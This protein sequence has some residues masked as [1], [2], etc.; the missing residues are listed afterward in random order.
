M[1]KITL[2]LARQFIISNQFDFEKK[3]THQIIQ[4]L[5]YVQ[6]DTISVIQRTHHHVLWTRNPKYQPEE[7]SQ[8]L[9]EKKI[10]DY[11][12]H[13]ASYLPMRDFRFSLI[14]K[15]QMGAGNGFWYDRN[16][17]NM[18]YILDRIKA[19]G[20][21]M[22]RD[23]KKEKKK[24]DT[25]WIKHPINQAMMQLFMEG[26]IMIVERQGLQKKFDLPERALPNNV[27]TKMP[28]EEEY[29]KYLI[30]RELNAQGLMKAREFGYLLKIDRKRLNILLGK[31]VK[32]GTLDEVEIKKKEGEKYFTLANALSDFSPKK[33]K[34]Q[35]HILSPF[36]NL[37]IQRKRL[38]ELFDFEYLLECYVPAAKREVGYFSLPILYGTDFMGQIDL[39]AD[40]KKKMLLVKNLVWEKDKK[41]STT[42]LNTFRKKLNALMNFN[43]CD[44]I[45]WKIKENPFK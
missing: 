31:M 33:N 40:R 10:F 1:K 35:V 7:L 11:W 17:K 30:K 32:N 19:E 14:R 29:F 21:L 28:S 34:K 37:I 20:A 27:N 38:K 3:S 26:K 16:P 5:G 15:S 42:F 12:A 9:K 18:K 24:S 22:S 43:N 36:D 8:L 45:H 41:I 25:P 2:K 39:K 23:F 44:E 4:Q 13:A 6:I